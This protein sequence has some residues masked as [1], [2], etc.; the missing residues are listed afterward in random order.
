MG[1]VVSDTVG[2]YISAFPLCIYLSSLKCSEL[3]FVEAS[4][5]PSTT[6]RYDT[7]PIRSREVE[8]PDV[9]ISADGDSRK[10]NENRLAQILK[11]EAGSTNLPPLSPQT[12]DFPT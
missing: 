1:R 4:Q 3:F 10:R 6:Q 8:Q 9:R 7:N 2:T 12:P 11:K 5:A